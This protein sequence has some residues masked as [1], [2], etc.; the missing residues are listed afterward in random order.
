[1]RDTDTLGPETKMQLKWVLSL[2][3]SAVVVGSMFASVKSDLAM[4]KAHIAQDWTDRDMAVWVAFF[5][6]QNPT[7]LGIPE[8]ESV[9]R[10]GL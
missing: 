6:N 3:A 9:K 8:V 2:L 1:M 7:N 5:K 4:M 10:F